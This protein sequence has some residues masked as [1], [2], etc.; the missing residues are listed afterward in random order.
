[1]SFVADNNCPANYVRVPYNSTVGTT[2]DFCL[3][4]YE[5]A[6]ASGVGTGPAL[7]TTST[8][9]PIANPWVNIARGNGPGDGGAIA[10]CQAIGSGYDLISNAEWQTVAETSRPPRTEVG[11]F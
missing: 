10:M 6:D 9:T 4:K 2:A 11:I 7:S 3:A 8:T 1:M 5:M